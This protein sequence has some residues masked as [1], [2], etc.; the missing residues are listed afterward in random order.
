M[1]TRLD[2]GLGWPSSRQH[3]SLTTRCWHEAMKLFS[4]EWRVVTRAYRAHR[5][6]AASRNLPFAL[7]LQEWAAVWAPWWDKRE[8]QGLMMCRYLD[9]GGYTKGNV[10]IGTAA[11]NWLDQFTV[12]TWN[13]YW[14]R[15]QA[16][17]SDQ[18][19]HKRTN[20]SYKIV[21]L[22]RKIREL[23]PRS[24]LAQPLHSSE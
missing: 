1:S 22:Q 24:M 6:S 23:A 5:R 9:M 20:L 10:Y 7:T 14:H 4:E 12:L 21:R 18:N 8:A 17:H 2:F 19:C 15:W 11:D 13:A 16:E 3:A